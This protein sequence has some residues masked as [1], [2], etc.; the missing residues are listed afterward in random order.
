MTR[1]IPGPRRAA[2]TMI[3]L[4]V[5]ILIIGVLA[6]ILLPAVGKVRDSARRAQAVTEISQ[7]SNAIGAFKAKKNVSY[8]PC[9]GSGTTFGGFLLKSTYSGSEPEAIYLKQLW[10]QLTL[11]ST[12]LPNGVELDANQTLMFFLTGFVPGMAGQPGQGFSTNPSA[13]FTATTGNDQRVGPFLDPNANKLDAAGHFTDPWGM[14][15]A[16]MAFEQPLN[17]YRT[18]GFT[19]TTPFTSSVVP[20]KDASGKFIHL[21]GFQIVS[22][23]KNKLFGPGGTTWN[24]GVGPYDQGGDDPTDTVNMRGWGGD[25]LSNF[26][27]GPLF[28]SD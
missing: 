12:G 24:P 10:P 22:A 2:F 4:L 21:R 7:I 1:R 26:N 25:D 5:V 20:Y 18:T 6:A 17:S 14:P 23:G 19:V 16:Y 8:I 15:Y 13:P 27:A 3:E 9:G 28:T 11:S